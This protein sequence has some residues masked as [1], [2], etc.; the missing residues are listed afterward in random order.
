MIK[1]LFIL[2]I[3]MF[4]G[5]TFSGCVSSSSD[6]KEPISFNEERAFADVENQ[7]AF[8]PRTPASEGHA[9]F[10]TWLESELKES[11]WQTTIQQGEMMGHP[12]KNI[13]ARRGDETPKILLIAHYDS[14]LLAD[15]DPDPGKHSFPVPGANDGASGV[16][17]LLELSRIL[18][19][20]SVPL[21][22]VFLDAEDNGHIPNWDWIL[23]SRYFVSEM[24]FRPQ[25]VVLV[26]MIGDADLNIYKEVNSDPGLTSQIWEVARNL[27][28][29]QYFIDETKHQ[30]L[31]DHVPF[32]EAG[33]PAVD[34]IDV[35]Y[36]YWHTT[37]DTADKV[38]KK[39]LEVVGDTLLQWILNQE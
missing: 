11:G 19:R 32:I 16:A 30:I 24:D 8:G 9:K 13:V 15:N 6:S 33:I 10:I 35:E 22:L 20:D 12:I 26:D 14:R 3:A 31:D 1:K 5:M 38:S 39:S 2:V 17:V 21:G 27:G 18:P 7:L 37:M 23:G 36:Q 34:I 28:Y 29:E 25:A 4:F